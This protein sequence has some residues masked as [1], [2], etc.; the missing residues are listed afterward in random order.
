MNDEDG[1]SSS[2]IFDHLTIEERDISDS[3]VR[4]DKHCQTMPKPLNTTY[5]VVIKYVAKSFNFTIIYN[6]S[7]KNS[8]YSIT[9]LKSFTDSSPILAIQ[10]AVFI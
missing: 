7:E 8:C 1:K 9:S 3:I 2:C 5:T 4:S 6:K 10:L